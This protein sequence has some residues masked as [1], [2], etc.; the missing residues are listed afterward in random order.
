MMIRKISHIAACALFAL[1]PALAS[2]QDDKLTIHGSANIGY[3][4]TDGLPYFGMTRDGTS[5]YRAIALQFGYKISDKDRVVTQLLHRNFGTSPL[6]AIQP[7]VEPVWAFYEHRFDNG[8][9]VK[10]GRNPLPRGLFNEVRFI[11]TLLPFYRVGSAVYGETL[12]FLDGVVVRKQV[13]V[14]D[15]WSVEGYLFGGGF[16]LKGQ[17]P[18]GTRNFVFNLRNENTVGTQV[19]LNTPI[20]GV[21]VGGFLASYQ[22][23]PAAGLP[24]SIRSPRTLTYMLSADGTFDK[25]FVRGEYSAFDTKDPNYIKVNSWYTSA[26]VMPTEKVTLA[27]EYSGGN[28]NIQLTPLPNLDLPLNK[29]LAFGVTYKPSAQV[30]FKLEAHKVD[31]YAFDVPVPSVIPPTAPPFVATL[32]PASKAYYGLLSVAFSF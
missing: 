4:K 12:E 16:D 7:V 20:K 30:A 6:K 1:T 27:V 13:D 26:G 28:N 29:D 25:A 9:S 17:I 11:G 23:T 2:A 15:D 32:A 10:L 8:T 18:V 3:G 19:W 22:Q 14:G 24:D 21:K 31:G 5:D